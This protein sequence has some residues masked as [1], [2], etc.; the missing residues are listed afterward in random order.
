M[1][2]LELDFDYLAS[3]YGIDNLV[4]VYVRVR[5]DGQ[6]ILALEGTRRD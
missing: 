1:T 6:R 4:A 2:K 3:T 5:D